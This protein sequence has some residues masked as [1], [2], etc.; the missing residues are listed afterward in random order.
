MSDSVAPSRNVFRVVGDELRYGFGFLGKHGWRMALWFVFLLMPIWGFAELVG[1]LHEKQ[2]FA[3]D[4]PTL[5]A[6][7][8]IA[9]PALNHFF[10]FVSR[11]GFLW[12]V[13]P[14]DA[15]VF[16]WLATRRRF[17][18]GLFFGLAVIGSATLDMV[19]KNYFHRARPDLWVSITPEYTYSFPSGHAMGSATLATALILLCWP[20]RWRWLVVAA[21]VVF[22]ALVGTSRVYLGVHYPSDIL[23]GWCAAV[24]WVVGMYALVDRKAARPPS[25]AATGD[26][27][28]GT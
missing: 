19:G 6:L 8:S 9:S 7:H 1:E 16:A 20:T 21:A 23:A 15:I 28:V 22:I 5:L 4:A 12:G 10:V 18:D 3:F 26:D 24:G 17:R 11:V 2:V 13:I 14:V 25:T 27:T